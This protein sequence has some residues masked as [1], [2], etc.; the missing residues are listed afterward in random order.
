[1]GIKPDA[2]AIHF[3][4]HQDERDLVLRL[5]DAFDATH[6]QEYD[7]LSFWLL[8]PTTRTR[9][10]FGLQ[11]EVLA[12]YSKHPKT[13]AR[14]LTAIDHITRHPDHRNRLDKVL[15]LVV[16]RGD[17]DETRKLLSEDKERVIVSFSAGELFDPARGDLFVRSRMAEIL[18]TIDVF[19]MSSPLVSDRYFFGRTELVQQLGRRAMVQKQNAGL[20][21]L[22]KTGKTSVLYATRRFLDQSPVLTDYFDCQNPGI[23]GA[24]WWQVLGNITTRLQQTLHATRNKTANIVGRYERHT[25]GT[26]FSSDIAT[27]LRTGALDQI[28]L[29]LD[30]IEWI[31]PGISGALGR[32]W[33]D[34]FIPFWQTMRA[35][36]QETE[37]RLI[38]IVAGV[39]PLSVQ[40]SHF[41][42]LP[43][44]VFQLATPFYLEPFAAT[45]VRDMVRTIGRYAGLSFD[46]AVFADLQR[47]YGGHPYLIRIACSEVWR[48]HRSLDAGAIKSLTPNDFEGVRASIRARLAQPIKDILLSLVWW[49]PDEYGLL[50]ILA[51]GDAEFVQQYMKANPDSLL[52][53]AQYGLLRADDADFAIMD[54]QEFLRQSGDEYKKELSPFARTD[55]RPE[56]LPATPNIKA[57]GRLFELKTSVEMKL[58]KMI[59]MYLGV[60]HSWDAEKIAN[61]MIKSLARREDRPDP[62]ALFTGRRP[63]DVINE[64]YTP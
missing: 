36:H 52:Q 1:M 31:T 59:L 5:D 50:Q 44:P 60:K 7:Q 49:Y 3:L 32:H 62:A 27:L 21:G 28:V 16:H 26:A 58:R 22:R 42:A 56:L 30:E 9:E 64:S 51:D 41:G 25:A 23:H 47:T 11:R 19:G 61:A 15:F 38:F 2:D 8:Q 48:L 6:G 57:L 40:R 4:G 53:F 37:G 12:V 54:I 13:D 24:R 35:T 39:N 63:Q 17:P 55:V 20:F 34:D 43:N 46:D 33:D 18:G 14:V 45:A 29:M 10:R